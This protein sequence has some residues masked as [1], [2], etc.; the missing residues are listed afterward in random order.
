MPTSQRIESLSPNYAVVAN[1]GGAGEALH[2]LA[3]DRQGVLLV[4]V[5]E[6]SIEGTDYLDWRAPY[7]YGGVTATGSF[8]ADRWEPISEI[9]RARG[10]IADFHRFHPISGNQTLRA[11]N[12]EIDRPTV[13]VPLAGDSEIPLSFNCSA[14]GVVKKAIRRGVSVTEGDLRTSA[15]HSRYEA[16]MIGK[17]ARTDLRFGPE[18][19]RCLHEGTRTRYLEARFEGRVVASAI[20][21]VGP[22]VAEYHLGEASEEGRVV[23]ATTLILAC[24]ARLF[25]S[26][27]CLWLFLGGGTT[28]DLSNGLYRFKSS[29]S[30]HKFVNWIGGTIYNAAYH[31]L[32]TL[33]PG[34]F[35]HYRSVAST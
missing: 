3:T 35:L 25:L 10:V 12:I 32:Q 5:I 2:L 28:P 18:Y 14:A 23:G 4:N 34:R 26:M 11:R 30:D 1:L 8:D 29:L 6:R 21:L 27:G 24:A 13:A 17:D 31:D 33:S 7:N 22:Q 9:A 20:F 19:F 15:F 16:L